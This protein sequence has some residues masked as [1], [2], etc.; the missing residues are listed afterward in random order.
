MGAVDVFTVGLNNFFGIGVSVH[1]R[2][3]KWDIVFALPFIFFAIY[4]HKHDKNNWFCIQKG[5]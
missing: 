2:S 1:K 3:G 5:A 4:A